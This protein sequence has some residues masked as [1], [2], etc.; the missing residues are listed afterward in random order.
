[1]SYTLV[2]SKALYF[3]VCGGVTGDYSCE[4]GAACYKDGNS[5]RNIGSVTHGPFVGDQGEVTLTYLVNQPQS[6]TCPTITTT[7]MLLCA[8]HQVISYYSILHSMMLEVKCDH[9]GSKEILCLP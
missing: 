5:S 9:T 7:L 4:G 2:G 1:M 3:S 6:E 8:P